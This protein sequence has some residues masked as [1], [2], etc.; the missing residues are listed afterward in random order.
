MDPQWLLERFGA[1]FFWVSAAIVFIEC[2]LLFPILPGDSLLFAV[3]LFIAQGSIDVNIVV[4]CLVLTLF[5]FAG[6]VS[7]YEIGR[8]VGTPLYER[9]G[10]FLK[11][12]YFDETHA[13]FEKHGAKALVLG[14]FVPIVRTFI[15][16]VAGVAR[17]DRRHFF[18]WSGVGALLWATGVTLLGY[19]LGQQFPVLKDNLEIAM[20]VIVA[21]SVVPMGIEFL[22]ARRARTSPEAVVEETAEA[23]R[24]LTD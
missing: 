21:I 23:A 10:R 19:F 17:M 16:V 9:D 22:R 4:A 7:G 14:R 6:N 2:G 15:T 3:G 12:K 1:Q 8:A 11:K 24:D 5:A 20:I 18:V 13:F